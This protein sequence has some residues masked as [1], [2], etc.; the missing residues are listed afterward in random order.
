MLAA[1]RLGL[2]AAVLDP[3]AGHHGGVVEGGV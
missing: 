1:H 2:H 3:G